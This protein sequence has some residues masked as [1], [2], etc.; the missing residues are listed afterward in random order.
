MTEAPQARIPRKS[1]NESSRPR[2]AATKPNV[3]GRGSRTTITCELRLV[4]NLIH[5]AHV[6]I[7]NVTLGNRPVLENKKR[8]R[9]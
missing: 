4:S 8:S 6:N 1:L 7:E 2:I 5:A 3:E 9:K